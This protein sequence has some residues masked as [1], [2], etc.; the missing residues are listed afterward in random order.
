MTA[1]LQLNG[2]AIP[3]AVDSATVEQTELGSMHRAVDG[4]PIVNRRRLLRR[5]NA[6]TTIRTAAEALAFRDLIS[7]KGHVFN[8]N[9]TAAA[10]DYLGFYSSKGLAPTSTGAQ[11]YS[12]PTGGKFSIPNPP[13]GA[14]VYP[15]SLVSVAG[16]YGTWPVFSATSAWTIAYYQN[17]AAAGFHHYVVRSDG[18]KWVDGAINPAA[19]DVSVSSG[20]MTLG[21]AGYGSYF[22]DV[23]C[24]PYAVPND[25]P[26]QMYAFNNPVGM[27]PR[28]WANGLFVEQNS[29]INVIGEVHEAKLHPG[30]LTTYAANLH[31]F[32]FSLHEV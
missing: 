30:V 11:F 5:W 17:R 29:L 32:A 9:G 7:G 20:A 4:T 10:F 18:S 23:I 1:F 19:Q 28:L 22:S 14:S 2:V 27:L 12:N 21:N 6:T 24:L 31:D 8:G 3:V 15:I 16:Y 13:L 25:W 26:A